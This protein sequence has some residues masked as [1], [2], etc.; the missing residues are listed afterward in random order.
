M[1]PWKIR[2][3]MQV[4]GGR[5]TLVL[6]ATLNEKPEHLGLKLAAYLL[7][8]DKELTV[9]AGAQHPALIG[10]DF[11]PDLLGTDITGSVALWVECGQTSQHKLLKVLRRWREAEVTVLKET[12]VQALRFRKD[13]ESGVP[14]SERIRILYWPVGGFSEWLDCLAEKTEIVGEAGDVSFNLVVNERVYAR[15]LLRG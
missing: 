10:Q 13:L 6:A 2:A 14:G 1:P 15:D 9:E 4:N 11:Q 5:R 7:Y 3:D 8:W 12:P